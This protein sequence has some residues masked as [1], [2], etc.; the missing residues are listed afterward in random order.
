MQFTPI[1]ILKYDNQHH[2]SEGNESTFYNIKDNNSLNLSKG[3]DS[4]SALDRKERNRS[5]SDAFYSPLN[6][7][8]LSNNKYNNISTTSSN[9]SNFAFHGN[10]LVTDSKNEM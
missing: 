3:I 9:N 1:N 6:N 5:N 8:I 10:F 2:K 4:F 7:N